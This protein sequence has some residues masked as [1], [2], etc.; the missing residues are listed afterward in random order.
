MGLGI[1]APFIPIQ[2]GLKGKCII[3]VVSFRA[4]DRELGLHF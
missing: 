1:P 4:I 2:S 3:G